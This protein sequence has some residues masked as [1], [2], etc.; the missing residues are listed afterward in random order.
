MDADYGLYVWPSAI[1][2]AEYIWQNPARFKGRQVL[3]VSKIF[4]Y[5]LINYSWVLGRR[6]RVY[7]LHQLA[8]L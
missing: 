1:V 3:E 8:Q 2:M 7:W 6:Y 4:L 5:S